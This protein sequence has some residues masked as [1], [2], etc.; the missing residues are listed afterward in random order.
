MVEPNFIEELRA[1]ILGDLPDQTIAIEPDTNLF[2]A[3][4]ID[5]L[6]ILSLVVFVEEQFGL[7]LDAEDLEAENFE[8]LNALAQLV[9]RKKTVSAGP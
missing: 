5:S 8:S 2:E 6:R 1:F 3:K 7:S 4:I 9:E